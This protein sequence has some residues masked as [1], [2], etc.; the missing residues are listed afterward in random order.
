MAGFDGL[1]VLITGAGTGLGASTA[2]GIARQGGRVII[3]YASSQREAEATADLCR[4]AGAEARVAQGNVADDADCRRIA[5][6]AADWGR[7]DA[8]INNAAA[9]RVVAHGDLEALS[10]DDFYSLYG[11]NTVGPFQM[12]RATRP[13]LEAGARASGRASSVVNVSSA[14]TFDGSGSSIAY[15]ASKAALNSM[16][17]SLARALGGPLIRV[18]AVCP[19]YMDSPWWLKARGEEG[20]DKLREAV[21]GTVPLRV[22]STP[23]DVAEAVMFLASPASRNMTGAVV[24]ADAGYCVSG[25]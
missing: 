16:T 6:L 25:H 14:S 1:N 18:N 5:A 23:E 8:L 9:T 24:M 4:T 12:V 7:L 21:R 20:A 22:A 17:Q 19:G 15:T 13:L 11:V 10:A 2:I 3:N